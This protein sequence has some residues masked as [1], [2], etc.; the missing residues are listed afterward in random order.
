VWN[1]LLPDE[2]L[3]RRYAGPDDVKG[4][5]DGVD[6]VFPHRVRDA[7]PS[8]KFYDDLRRTPFGDELV[9]DAALEAMTAHQLGADE[10]PD[11]LAVG[12]S[13]GDVIGHTYGPDSQETMDEYLRLDQVIGRLLDEVDRRVGLDRVIVGLCADHGVMPLV[14]GL[15]ARGL[16]AR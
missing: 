1:R 4:E 2:A 3:Y 9:L 12:F 11:V 10:D 13:S 7:P 15:Q 8:P 6:T 16:P 5:W 14:E